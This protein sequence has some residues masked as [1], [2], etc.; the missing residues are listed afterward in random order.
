MRITPLQLTLSLAI[1]LSW[2]AACGSVASRR[3][4]SGAPPA[5]TGTGDAQTVGDAGTGG[6]TGAAG[7][8]GGTGGS[9]GAGGAGGGGVNGIRVRGSIGALRPPVPSAG[10]TILVVK[11]RLDAPGPSSCGPAVCLV[12]GGIV[13]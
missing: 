12:R 8:T 2:V 13:P 10:G 6:R 11:P 7:T 9:T 1:A 4:D 3:N 5:D